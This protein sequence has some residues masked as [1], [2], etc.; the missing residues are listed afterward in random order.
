MAYFVCLYVG[1]ESK[2]ESFSC[3]E[4]CFTVPSDW[5]KIQNSCRSWYLFEILANILQLQG[6]FGRRQIERGG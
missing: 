1:A 3:F 6:R 4:H 2:S 5:S